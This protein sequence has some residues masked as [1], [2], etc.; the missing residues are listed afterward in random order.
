V[1]IVPRY[2][3]DPP[4]TLDA[5]GGFMMWPPRGFNLHALR[6]EMETSIAATRARIAPI[7]L[8][9]LELEVVF[10]GGRPPMPRPRILAG[11]WTPARTEMWAAKLVRH[12]LSTTRHVVLPKELARSDDE[13]YVTEVGGEVHDLGPARSD[14]L[15]YV[16]WKTGVY[17]VLACDPEEC[18]VIAATRSGG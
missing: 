12:G 5:Y 18:F 8:T 9:K 6:D 17:W 16:P 7:R 11:R 10:D 13:I 4:G 2:E 1:R 14:A 3:L 15:H